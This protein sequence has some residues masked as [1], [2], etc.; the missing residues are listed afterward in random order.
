[1]H[2]DNDNLSFRRQLTLTLLSNPSFKDMLPT[3]NSVA[4]LCEYVGEDIDEISEM[5]EANQKCKG[6]E[7]IQ[8][9]IAMYIDGLVNQVIKIGE[10]D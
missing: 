6:V 10:L 2:S 4:D 9:A 7:L 1:M 8:T 3:W 5:S